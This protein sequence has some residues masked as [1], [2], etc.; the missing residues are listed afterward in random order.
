MSSVLT[1]KEWCAKAAKWLLWNLWYLPQPRSRQFETHFKRLS[2][3][4]F[5][6]W[7]KWR[8]NVRHCDHLKEWQVYLSDEMAYSERR[9][10]EV[11]AM[12]SDRTGDIVGF[13]VPDSALAAPK[14]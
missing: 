3:T 9:T 14:Q 4:G 7:K 11:D 2:R 10:I 1:R 13:D 6:P 12:I 8:P 5:P